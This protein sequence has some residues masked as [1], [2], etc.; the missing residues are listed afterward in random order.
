MSV[1]DNY[2][3]QLPKDYDMCFYGAC[4]NF[5]IQPHNLIPNKNIYKK[6]VI[7]TDW[8]I[9]STRALYCYMVSKRG[10]INIC[11]YVDNIKYKINLPSDQWLNVVA[12][13]I[14]LNIYW[15]EPT[16][17]IQGTEIGLFNKSY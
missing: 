10:A 3:K 2:M 11:D 14:N 4:C 5:N 8:T 17:A 7:P 16:I 9:G 12:R 15:A 1:L 13:H 6:S